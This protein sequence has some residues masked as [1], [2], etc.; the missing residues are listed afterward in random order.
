MCFE[1]AFLEISTARSIIPR[2]PAHIAVC[3]SIFKTA[4]SAGLR[5]IGDDVSSVKQRSW[6]VAGKNVTLFRS[7]KLLFFSL[8]QAAVYNSAANTKKKDG[9]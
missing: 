6:S 9:K 7:Q 4:F 8:S 3:K 1:L 5:L 2:V